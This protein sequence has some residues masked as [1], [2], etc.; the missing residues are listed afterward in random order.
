MYLPSDR[1][2]LR[3]T[4]AIDCETD[5]LGYPISLTLDAPRKFIDRMGDG[6]CECADYTTNA[7]KYGITGYNSTAAV[8]LIYV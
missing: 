4:K 1:T 5:F 7:T 3:W 6:N 2:V 8:N